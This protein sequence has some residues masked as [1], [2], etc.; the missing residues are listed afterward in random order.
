VKITTVFMSD[1]SFINFVHCGSPDFWV[2][3]NWLVADLTFQGLL[4]PNHL[5]RLH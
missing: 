5:P 4:S 3:L 2:M 1:C